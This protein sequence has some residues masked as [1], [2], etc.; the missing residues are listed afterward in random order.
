MG[1]HPEEKIENRQKLKSIY[2]L[3][4]IREKGRNIPPFYPPK[5]LEHLTLLLII[6]WWKKFLHK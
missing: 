5:Y 4:L 6:I 1:V 2:L 3:S